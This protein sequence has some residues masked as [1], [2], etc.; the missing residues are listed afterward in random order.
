MNQSSKTMPICCFLH[1]LCID[2]FCHQTLDV[3]RMQHCVKLQAANTKVGTGSLPAIGQHLWNISYLLQIFIAHSAMGNKHFMSLTV[4]GGGGGGNDIHQNHPRSKSHTHPHSSY[5]LR[6]SG[7]WL[8]WLSISASLLT[9]C[10]LEQ[11]P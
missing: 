6:K 5:L 7:V 9:S 10:D 3:V 11:E 8:S 4:F 1:S 2:Y